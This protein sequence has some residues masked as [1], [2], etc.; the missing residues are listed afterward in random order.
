M[1]FSGSAGSRWRLI[2]DGRRI[3]AAFRDFSSYWR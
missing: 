3:E 2:V 1:A